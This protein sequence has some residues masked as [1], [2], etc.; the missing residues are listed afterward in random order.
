[1][2]RYISVLNTF[3]IRVNANSPIIYFINCGDEILKMGFQWQNITSVRLNNSTM[4]KMTF[5]FNKP[6]N[7]LKIYILNK[8]TSTFEKQ[9]SE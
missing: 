5:I 9:V 7:F 6:L 1:M 3:D 2:N 8:I 4:F